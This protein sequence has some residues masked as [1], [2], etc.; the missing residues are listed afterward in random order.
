MIARRRHHTSA[1][2]TSQRTTFPAGGL[3][4][5]IGVFEPTSVVLAAG[6]TACIRDRLPPAAQTYHTPDRIDRVDV[7]A[8]L[9][10]GKERGKA[11]KLPWLR[12]VVR[13]Y[14]RVAFPLPF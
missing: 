14:L 11:G 6:R 3:T 13:S 10:I 1:Q 2:R 7:A 8:I 4:D 12:R 5:T 9:R